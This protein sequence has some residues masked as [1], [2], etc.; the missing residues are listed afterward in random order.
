MSKFESDPIPMPPPI[1]PE[2]ALTE[3]AL[4]RN[5]VRARS[6]RR[7]LSS[8]FKPNDWG[9]VVIAGVLLVVVIVVFLTVMALFGLDFVSAADSSSEAVSVALPTAV[10]ARVD[11]GRGGVRGLPSRLTLPDGGEISLTPWDGSER[12]TV[13]FLGI[14]RRPGENGLG[15][16]T[17]TIIIASI[18]PRSNSIGLLSIPRDLYVAL[19]GYSNRQRINT[20]MALG[21]LQRIGYGPT[22]ATV[23]FQSNFNMPIDDYVVADFSVLIALIDAM[24]GIDVNVPTPIAD[25]DFPDMNYGYDPLV[26]NTGL[27]HMDGY[28][29]QKYARTR[30]G[31]SDFERAGRQQEVIF[32][33]REQAVNLDT[34]PNLILSAPLLYSNVQ[35][36]ITTSMGLEEL[37]R[38]ALYLK[39]IPR[40]NIHTAVMDAN[41]VADFMTEDGADVL[42]PYEGSLAALFAATFGIDYWQ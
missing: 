25:Y 9:W 2:P 16:R 4:P 28:I 21:E 24:G 12:L 5:A 42:V 8:T 37:I 22:F 7:R 17:D 10:N 19:P 38:L 33:I 41:Y 27:Q 23:A 30:H 32:A 6:Q 13:L 39:D 36:N 14:D 31:D 18:D 11:Y 34:L 29:A 35:E 40:E 3:V 1:A 15:Y 26:L 20:A